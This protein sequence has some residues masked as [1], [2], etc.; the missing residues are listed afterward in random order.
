MGKA[1]SDYTHFTGVLHLCAYNAS[2]AH[3]GIPGVSVNDASML[4]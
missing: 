4:R 2:S 1:C 3:G